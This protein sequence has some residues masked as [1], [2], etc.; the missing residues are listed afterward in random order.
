MVGI[1]WNTFL[2]DLFSS[3]SPEED[4]DTDVEDA[5]YARM[6]FDTTGSS[7]QDTGKSVVR[8][9]G[10]NNKINDCTTLQMTDYGVPHTG[11]GSSSGARDQGR[12]GGE[13]GDGVAD[14]WNISL[15]IEGQDKHSHLD[16]HTK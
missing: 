6:Y 16:K 13:E 11:Q 2:H 10:N 3:N 4:L 1:N 8:E 15:T 5:I 12:G 7:Q 9:L 14:P